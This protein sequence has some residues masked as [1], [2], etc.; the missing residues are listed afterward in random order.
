MSVSVNPLIADGK[1]FGLTI[2]R[3]ALQAALVALLCQ[4]IYQYMPFVRI[5][6]NWLADFRTVVLQHSSAQSENL[7]ILTI[8]EETLARLPYRSP[9][10]R[11][12]LQETLID[13]ESRGVRAVGF[14][15]LF[16]TATEASRDQ[17]F[18]TS[19]QQSKVPLVVAWAE[20]ED[21][22]TERQLS[23]LGEHLAGLPR[24]AADR[25]RRRA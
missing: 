19:L 2:G 7:V 8:T 20:K 22:V 17:A 15:L 9:V 14:D 11:R 6:E 23:F 10:D 4:L 5:A 16:D 21:G 24:G 18:F 3:L 13:L 12:L 25:A 1:L